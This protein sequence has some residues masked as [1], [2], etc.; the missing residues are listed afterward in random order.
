[1]ILTLEEDTSDPSS[2][3]AVELKIYSKTTKSPDD[4]RRHTKDEMNKRLA[5]V[6]LAL[7][8]SFM[9]PAIRYISP[10][11]NIVLLERPPTY[12]PL[13]FS[14][15]ALKH[16][17]LEGHSDTKF[18][19][20][21]PWQRYVMHLSP[22]G[23]VAS[24]G[25]YF[26]PHEIKNL[27]S[28]P[29]CLAPLPNFYNTGLMCLPQFNEIDIKSLSLIDAVSEAFSLVWNTGFNIDTVAAAL[30]HTGYCPNPNPL[31]GKFND[32][33]SFYSKWSSYTLEEV[34]TWSWTQVYS[35][36][37]ESLANSFEADGIN[38]HDFMVDIYMA[39]Q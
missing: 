19:I 10:Q 35:S 31:K 39:S 22:T 14:P 2:R 37:N 28:D 5:N 30:Q 33:L 26:S 36:F 18:N 12:M 25:C 13:N 27:N 21:I 3:S 1:M 7:P 16:L 17:S 9:P 11:R 32:W 6:K 38:L 4:T 29:M 15:K 20:P 34:M 23:A 8:N 24:L